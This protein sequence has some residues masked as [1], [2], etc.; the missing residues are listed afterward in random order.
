LGDAVEAARKAVKQ[1]SAYATRDR[2]THIRLVCRA[3]A[4]F[5]DSITVI[6]T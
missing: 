4:V 5:V 2:D 3:V 1:A 6:I